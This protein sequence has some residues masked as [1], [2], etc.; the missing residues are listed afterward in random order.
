MI[1]KN[2]PLHSMKQVHT[3]VFPMLVLDEIAIEMIGDAV[4]R[5]L[6]FGFD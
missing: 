4:H 6:R 3:F 1:N 2:V 5:C